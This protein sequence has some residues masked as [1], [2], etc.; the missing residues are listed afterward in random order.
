[1]QFFDLIVTEQVLGREQVFALDLQGDLLADLVHQ[2]VG[3]AAGLSA[4]A[5]VAAAAPHHGGEQALA[6][7]AD[8]QGAVDEHLQRDGA[9]LFHGADVVEGQ[10][11]GQNSPLHALGGQQTG[12]VGVVDSHLGAGVDRQP[13]Y[14]LA[15]GLQQADIL[16]DDSVHA[17]AVEL[18]G[19][20]QESPQLPVAYQGVGGYVDLDPVKMGQTHSF[21]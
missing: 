8:A 6:A 15:Q 11:P 13:R 16:H 18:G 10:L 21:F 9:L 20:V 7:E 5:A 1:M 12:G 4:A 19:V 3:H 2:A 14:C 17:H